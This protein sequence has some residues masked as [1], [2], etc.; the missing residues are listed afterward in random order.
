MTF[1]EFRETYK[2]RLT[3]TQAEAVRSVEGPVLLL[4]VPGSGKTT[5][6]VS[7]LGYMII[8]CGIPPSSV[9]TMT[10]TV[11]A[12]K[13]M[14]NRFCS[15][16]GE[17][18]RGI[19][20]F[21]TINGVCAKIIRA[22]ERRT[23]RKAFRL[24]D[25]E[26]ESARLIA[27]V[28]KDI[29][30]HMPEEAE[31][32][33]TATGITY[34]KNMMYS[35]KELDGLREAPGIPIRKLYRR[36]CEVMRNQRAMDYD[37]QM[38]YAHR[39]LRKHPQI[40]SEI[41]NAYRYICVDE[42]QDTSRIQ[43][44]II[45]LLA[46]KRDNLFMVG[47]EDQSIYGFRAAYPK[48]LLVFE[49]KHPGA[50]LLFMEENFRSDANIVESAERFIC[51]NPSRHEKTMYAAR[52]PR[53]AVTEIPISDR[54]KQYDLLLQIAL[55]CTEETAILYRN[56]A[57]AI[58]LIDLLE[59]NGV[60]YQLRM[61]EPSFF[62]NHIVL[63]LMQ[64]FRLAY[65]PR[66][67][68]A[69]LRVYNKLS[70]HA[71]I[72]NPQKVCETAKTFGIT[73]WEAAVL[74]ENRLSVRLYVKSLERKL[75]ALKKK[76]ADRAIAF[77]QRKTD[78]ESYLYSLEESPQKL[79]LL[80]LIGRFE[81]SPQH[82]LN[83]MRELKELIVSGKRNERASFILST[84]H[85]AKGLEYDTVYLMDVIDGVFPFEPIDNPINL[86]PEDMAYYEEERRLFYVG[87]TR[88]KNH[89]YLLRYDDYE[90]SFCDEF[91]QSQNADDMEIQFRQIV[92]PGYIDFC[93]RIQNG[94]E[95]I[96]KKFGHAKIIALNEH[97]IFARFEDII[98][99]LPLCELYAFALLDE[100]Q[101]FG[102]YADTVKKLRKEFFSHVNVQMYPI[103]IK[104]N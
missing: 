93:K 49:E 52:P 29:M 47:D 36:Y 16:F 78:Y 89:L 8:G 2:L 31:I 79:R 68:E 57:S 42:A 10:Y 4:A 82:F 23:G 1:E 40:L 50:K 71:P 9:L 19:V 7:R 76:R 30:G 11:A 72:R 51:R 60:S 25:D 26:R 12:T 83:R 14:K 74:T 28:W 67:T 87:I 39:I 98:R 70:R 38:L 56:N 91:F 80:A 24:I 92:F 15:F 27:S 37:D 84:V 45:T 20:E 103:K 41:Q 95:I 63:D 21:R 32:R 48:A 13:D 3:E 90:S 104:K 100:K 94:M 46:G 81:P 65:N 22:Y 44:E 17:E 33:Q 53:Y 54:I 77:I 85:S 43:H 88:A 66:D 58:P 101:L 102:A 59:R 69:F 86:F 64:T 55:D 5:V 62:T 97:F 99:A 34:I 6:L 96:H 35:E 73:V 61:P 18:W 75:R